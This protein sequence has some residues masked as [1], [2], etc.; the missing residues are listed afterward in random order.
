MYSTPKGRN[1]DGFPTI[2]QAQDRLEFLFNK[3]INSAKLRRLT[4]QEYQKR[5]AISKEVR[6]MQVNYRE[7]LKKQYP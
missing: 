5:Y 6:T 2:K 3:G 7:E 1:D 4:L